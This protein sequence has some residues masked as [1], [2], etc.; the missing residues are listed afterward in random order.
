MGKPIQGQSS[1]ELHHDGQ[2]H[3]KNPGSGGVEGVGGQ[4]TGKTVDPHLPE[5]QGQR[6]LDN[7]D[8]QKRGPRGEVGGAAAQ[9]RIPETAETVASEATR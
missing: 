2:A 8:A 4:A 3:R 9:D 5:N 6:A 1:A 7:E